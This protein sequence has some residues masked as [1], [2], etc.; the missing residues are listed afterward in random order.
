MGCEGKG[1]PGKEEGERQEAQGFAELC[2]GTIPAGLQERCGS[3][4]RE[5]MARCMA[6]FQ[7]AGEGAEEAGQETGQEEAT[8]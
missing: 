4:M 1:K 8:S 6:G 3:Q 5:M 2:R 7:A